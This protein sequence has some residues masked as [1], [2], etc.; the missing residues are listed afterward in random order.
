MRSFFGKII[1]SFVLILTMGCSA[2]ET[3][4]GET[5]LRPCPA[6]P[7]CVLS[8]GGDADHLIAPILYR[9]DRNSARQRIRRIVSGMARTRII[10][11]QPDY[12]HVEFRS[13]IMGFVDD[14]EFW[15]PEKEKT[16]HV[17]S[18]ARVGYSDLGV[19]RARIEEIRVLYGKGDD[20]E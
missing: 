8:T 3:G 16:I 18:A 2:S 15:L 13:R 5:G 20:S 6:R 14:V 17:R 10:T 11:D 9:T 7:N 19:N 1:L 4:L 12:L